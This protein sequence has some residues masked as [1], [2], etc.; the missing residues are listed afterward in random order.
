MIFFDLMLLRKLPKESEK[1]DMFL[2]LFEKV[3]LVFFTEIS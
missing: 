2:T 1:P 3:I